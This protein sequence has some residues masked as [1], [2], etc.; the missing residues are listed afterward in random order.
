MR[1]H[2]SK[3][4]SFHHVGAATKPDYVVVLADR[5][6]AD[7][8]QVRQGQPGLCDPGVKLLLYSSK[9]L[10]RARI[11]R[12]TKAR[13]AQACNDVLRQDKTVLADKA[14]KKL[15]G[16]SA[17]PGAPFCKHLEQADLIG[18]R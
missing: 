6:R 7:S 10:F 11:L 13:V 16:V 17:E 8:R 1:L 2:R 14:Q 12:D 3:N 9:V 4:I 15:P 18:R 5:H